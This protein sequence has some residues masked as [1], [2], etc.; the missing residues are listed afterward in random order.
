MFYKH[1]FLLSFFQKSSSF[2]AYVLF[3]PTVIDLDRD[4]GELD[5]V[6]GTS[7]GNLHVFNSNGQHRNG[8]PYSMGT[9]HGQVSG[10]NFHCGACVYGMS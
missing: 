1:T 9:I 7:A 8:F 4:G 5:I 3:S 6:I 2:P 10:N